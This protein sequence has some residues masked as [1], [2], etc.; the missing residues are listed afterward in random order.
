[1][2]RNICVCINVDLEQSGFPLECVGDS[3]LD[4]FDVVRFLKEVSSWS[5]VSFGF[6]V[7]YLQKSMQISSVV[8][9]CFAT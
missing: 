7:C 4:H 2:S 3:V 5:W 6:A 8:V 9:V 1:M